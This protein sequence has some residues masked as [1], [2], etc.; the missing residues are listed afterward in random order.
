MTVDLLCGK[1]VPN[2]LNN[3]QD[4]FLS[5]I[6]LSAHGPLGAILLTGYLGG[7]IAIPLRIGA[8]LFSQLM[9][10]V[11]LGLLMWSGLWMRDRRV[12]RLFPLR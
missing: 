12:R 11:Y 6:A 4:S 5:T 2:Y 1:L 7:A 8:Q 3:F 10:G 9:L